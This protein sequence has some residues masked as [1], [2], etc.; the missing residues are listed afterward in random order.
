MDLVVTQDT[1]GDTVSTS[2]GDAVAIDTQEIS[3]QV[4]VE[5]GGNH[6]TRW[7]FP[8]KLLKR[9]AKSTTFGGICLLWVTYSKTHQKY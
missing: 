9:C 8:T 5:N 1:R 2:T 3:T 4:L 6:S 7:N